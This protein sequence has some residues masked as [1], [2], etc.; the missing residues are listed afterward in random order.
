VEGGLAAAPILCGLPLHRGRLRVLHL[1]PIGRAAGAV[2]LARSFGY[3]VVRRHLTLRK[4]PADAENRLD[5]RAWDARR[6]PRYC[7]EGPLQQL[8]VEPQDVV[9]G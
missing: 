3:H 5:T 2:E 9:R 1:E 4:C 7:V 8:A 6:W